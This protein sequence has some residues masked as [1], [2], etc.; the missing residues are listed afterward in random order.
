MIRNFK[1]GQKFDP[2]VT[3]WILYTSSNNKLGRSFHTI[4]MI[5]EQIKENF[6]KKYNLK[7]VK[8][9]TNTKCLNSAENII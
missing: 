5:R 2:R 3:L 1:F 7:N 9:I 8:W 4:S 6:I